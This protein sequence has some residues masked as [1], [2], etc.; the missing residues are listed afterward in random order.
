[1][2]TESLLHHAHSEAHVK[3]KK[4]TEDALLEFIKRKGIIRVRDLREHGFHPETL[5]RLH[6]DGRLIRRSRGMYTH[7]DTA[8]TEHQTLIEVFKR[9]PHGVACLLTALRFHDIGTQNPREVWIALERG[10][11]KPK[12][13]YPRLRVVRFSGPAMTEG[14]E[15]HKLGGVSVRVYNVAKTVADCFRFRNKIG[16]D[17]AIEALS[18]SLRRGRCSVDDIWR[19]AKIRRVT[20]TIQPYLTAIMSR[21]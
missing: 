8:P 9:V 11:R 15:H 16:L 13:E 10:T 20:N 4:P 3:E 2:A 5:R 18:D 17:I 7:P 6:R 14:I 12:M 19:Y 21:P 1:M